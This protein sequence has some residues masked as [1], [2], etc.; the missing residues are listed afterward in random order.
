LLW[1][2]GFPPLRIVLIGIV[3]AFAGYAS[4]Y[5]LND[6]IDCSEDRKRLRLGCKDYGDYL[7]AAMLRHPVAECAISMRA[8]LAWAASWGGLA[9]AGAAVLNPICALIFAA[10][11]LVE[12]GYCLLCRVTPF[13][14]L[15]SGVV[16]S[17]GPLAA[18]YAVDPAPNPGR[19]LLLFA[20]LYLWEIG[21][22][23]IPSDWSDVEE[24]L[25]LGHKTLPVMLNPAWASRVALV[26]VTAS[27]A[28][29]LLV[30]RKTTIAEKA[31]FLV[32]SIAAGILLLIVP[33]LKLVRTRT[34]ADALVVFNRASYYPVCMLAS[35]SISAIFKLL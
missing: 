33:A 31:V 9:L 20:W 18:I 11:F 25:L 10:A 12:V 26:S 29:S 17:A 24:D 23:N 15:L 13:R 7:D 28:V 22:Q 2:G 5:A 34:R 1:I 4:V 27:V 19:L 6:I 21:G 32:P 8:A 35:A 3:T 14:T 30:A 16:K